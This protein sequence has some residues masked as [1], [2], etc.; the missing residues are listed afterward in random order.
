ML[1]ELT[2]PA[3]LAEVANLAELTELIGLLSYSTR[4][5]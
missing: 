3:K 2:N 4:A 5:R 1:V